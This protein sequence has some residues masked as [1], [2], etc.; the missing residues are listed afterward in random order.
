[1]VSLLFLFF[2]LLLQLPP[3]AA[4]AAAAAAQ[5]H[6][7][8]DKYRS[9]NVSLD[10]R[11]GD[12]THR[13]LVPICGDTP[14]PLPPVLLIKSVCKATLSPS[15]CRASLLRHD[16][17]LINSSSTPPRLLLLA[18]LH[19]AVDVAYSQLL[20]SASLSQRVLPSQQLPTNNNN[21]SAIR[22]NLTH[23]SQ[24]CSYLLHRGAQLHRRVKTAISSSMASASSAYSQ[25]Q[26]QQQ[27][28]EEEVFQCHVADAQAWLSA[29]LTDIN[30][31]HSLA[32]THVNLTAAAI[33]SSMASANR[34]SADADP[35]TIIYKNNTNI[36]LASLY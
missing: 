27:Q 34:S 7:V 21:N 36:D 15:V 35:N 6:H 12:R 10:G 4:A 26:E 11:G 17:K 2:L 22:L 3:S 16:S 30:D 9:S 25:H 29:A 5:H 32:L 28:E 20:S 31:C 13:K 8:S 24:D 14:P 23:V 18:V 33:R 19:L 1:M